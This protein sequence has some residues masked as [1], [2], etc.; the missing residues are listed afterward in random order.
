MVYFMKGKLPWQGLKTFDNEEKE[1]TVMEEKI[2]ISPERL[3]KGLPREFVAYFR[4]V[5]SLH[6][7]LRPNYS[8]LK[9][10]I[11]DMAERHGVEHDDI[12]DWTVRLYQQQ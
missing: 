4:R 7:G 6:H 12:F 1:Q 8:E 9:Q 10:L 11:S 2:N 5:K 3:C